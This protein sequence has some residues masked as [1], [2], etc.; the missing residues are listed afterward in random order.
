M[1]D[2]FRQHL[3]SVSAGE[4]FLLALI[5]VVLRR[6]AGVPDGAHLAAVCVSGHR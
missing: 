6:L 2:T 1:M 4:V 3:K 5:G